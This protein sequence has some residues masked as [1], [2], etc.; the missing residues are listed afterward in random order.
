MK[1]VLVTGGAGFIGAN[2]IKYLLAEFKYDIYSVDSYITG[3]SDNHI[4]GCEYLDLSDRFFHL[5]HKFDVIF[6]LGA[7]AR[8][9]PSL[10]YP[11]TTLENNIMSTINVLDYAKEKGS[12][13]IYAG[14]S[15]IHY[16]EYGS[17][18]SFSKSCG[19]KLCKL[20]SDVYDVKTSICR[21]YNVYGDRMIR[22]GSY[23]TVI[24]IFQKQYLNKDPFTVVG[25][26]E[27]KRDF[28]HIDDIVDGLCRCMIYGKDLKAEIFELGSGK[29]YSINEVAGMFRSEYGIKY[30]KKRSG[31]YLTTLCDYSKAKTILGYDPKGDLKEYIQNWIKSVSK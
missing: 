14:S 11:R 4:E 27:Q 26:G 21:F 3:S 13:V 19:E 16:N 6:H 22:N 1:K 23:A 31:E 18:Y 7:L 10:K 12:H 30:L 20:Y 24:G 17:P 9:Q 8:I 29:N 25:D 2:L 5:D 15:S 28:T